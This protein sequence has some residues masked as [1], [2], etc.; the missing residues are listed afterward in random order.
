MIIYKTH[1]VPP[2]I[3]GIRFSDYARGIFTEIPSRKGIRKAI[4]RGELLID[5]E[6]A[7][8]GVWINPGQKIDLIRP[9]RKPKDYQIDIDVVYEDDYL[10][11]VNKPAGIQVNGNKFKTVENALAGNLL[12]SMEADALRWPRPV[13]R[14]D[15]STSGL[16]I[17]AKTAGAQ[18]GL[19]LQFEGRGIMKRYRAVVIGKIDGS[20]TIDTP[21][22]GRE[23]VTDYVPVRIVP[24][25]R[26]TWL[27]LIDL[28]PKT[29]RTHQLRRHMADSGYPI[30]G[31][32][33][34]GI[35]GSI[36][37]SKG[38]FLSAVELV[39]LHPVHNKTMTV[40]IQEPEKFTTFLAREERRWR[41]YHPPRPP[42]PVET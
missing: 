1:I 3:S 20:G 38:L 24:S 25:L 9:E 32:R 5:E 33:I 29:G 18:R 21:I 10:A 26:N 28:R 42:I 39:F 19:G 37:V 15:S 17:I 30:L 27:T 6:V 36:L 16:L 4:E 34:Y 22:D 41:T 35:E 40:S 31:D 23:S 2:G 7:E 13:H 12:P 8:T 14:L 11:V